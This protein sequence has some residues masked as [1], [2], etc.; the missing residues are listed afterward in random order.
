MI[1][2]SDADHCPDF[3]GVCYF[4]FF[5]PPFPG[6]TGFPPPRGVPGRDKEL[7]EDLWESGCDEEEE[8]DEVFRDDFFGCFSF[9]AG[10]VL[11]TCVPFGGSSV[12]A[13]LHFG[14]LHRERV[15]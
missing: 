8:E 15:P 11:R 3:R 14:R 5:F 9:F 10:T 7:D 2:V 13:N 6:F 12:C 4:L 1:R